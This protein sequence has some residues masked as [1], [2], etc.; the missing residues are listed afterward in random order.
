[1]HQQDHYSVLGVTRHASLSDVKKAYRTAAKEKH[2]DRNPGGEADFKK[3][4]A[5]YA[6]L[7]D[8]DAR[9]K[10][11][12]REA[13]IA[14][15]QCK[16]D[17]KEKINQARQQAKKT[18]ENV[19]GYTMTQAERADIEAMIRRDA[20]RSRKQ[21]KYTLPSLGSVP[22]ATGIFSSYTTSKAALLSELSK[23]TERAAEDRTLRDELFKDIE[24]QR[25]RREK[26]RAARTAERERKREERDLRAKDDQERDRI[27]ELERQRSANEI[28]KLQALTRVEL[29]LAQDSREERF[30][31]LGNTDFVSDIQS[32][33]PKEPPRS[34]PALMPLLVPSDDH[35]K[36]VMPANELLHLANELSAKLELVRKV[37]L[38]KRSST[39]T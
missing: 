16:E 36:I 18:G 28:S 26:E 19:S 8:S 9:Q 27:R 17:S 6:I 13:K 3:L 37:Y 29:Q 20:E 32:T 2:P 15:Q 33:V 35:I 21:R 1:M 24:T 5:A 12:F 38:E 14:I 22:T 39:S 23:R 31:C 30:A 10:Y 4:A 34:S 25:L 11:D 7:S